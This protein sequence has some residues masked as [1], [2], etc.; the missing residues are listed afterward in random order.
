[1]DEEKFGTQDEQEPP[2]RA[3][4]ARMSLPARLLNVFAVPGQV[5]EELSAAPTL[6]SNWLVPA[7]LAALVGIIS[8]T[9]LISQPAFQKQFHERQSRVIE[10]ATKAGRLTP[11][12]RNLLD[13]MTRPAVL[14]VIGAAGAAVGSFG[15]I[16]WWGFVLW[17]LARI[18]IRVQVPFGRSM[19][20]AGLTMMINVLG[21][22]VLLALLS[23]LGQTAAAPNLSLLSKDANAT[24]TSRS[25][26]IVVNVFSVWVVA[27]RA[28]G[29]AKLTGTSYFRAGWAVFTFW[30]MEQSLLI[31]IGLGQGSF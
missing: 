29:L 2:P 20:V 13:Q 18:I 12:E 9:V 27:V 7:V 1:M 6:M 10:Q 8:A 14:K 22:V 4:R 24:G 25:L 30:L 23:N 26:A 3:V 11:Q 16:L 21:G 28:I 15:N 19:E 5:F 17:F 31:L